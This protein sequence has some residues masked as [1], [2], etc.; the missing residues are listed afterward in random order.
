LV[1]I[2]WINC[3]AALG[4]AAAIAVMIPWIKRVMAEHAAGTRS[5]TPGGPGAAG[6]SGA[7]AT[8]PVA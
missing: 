7:R 5:S 4:A 3:A 8:Q 2:F 6:Q 1:G